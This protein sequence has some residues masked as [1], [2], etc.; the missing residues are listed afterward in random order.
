MENVMYHHGIIG[1]RWGVR[2]YQNS[3]GTWT[4]A[5]KKRYG[6]GK[7]DSGNNTGDTR[8]KEVVVG[9]ATGAA[10][11]AGTVLTAYLV[12]KYG[13][14]NLPAI[15]D[16]ASSGKE[17][18]EDLLK[19]PSVSSTPISKLPSQKVEV[20]QVLENVAKST[21]VTSFQVNHVSTPTVS[22]SKPAYTMP[23]TYDYKTL[24]KQNDELLKKMYAELLS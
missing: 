10:V 3:D 19:S 5:G 20:K 15:V 16:K 9:V 22:V 14:N 7:S 4:N 1:Q 21:P 11:V 23:Q 2:R 17:I 13:N 8:K 18:I 24:M 12:K 6:D